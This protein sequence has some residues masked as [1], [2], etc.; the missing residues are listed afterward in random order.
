MSKNL[1]KTM[2]GRALEMVGAVLMALFCFLGFLLVLKLLFPSGTPLS[3]LL[4]GAG[5][6]QSPRARNYLPE[7][8]SVEPFAASLTRFNNSVK[9]KGSGDIAWSDARQNMQ[10]YNR[11]AVQTA[12]DSSA[13]ISFDPSNSLEMAS[14]SLVI[15]KS[16]TKDKARNERKSVLLVIDG[17]LRGTL[18]GSGK[19]AVQV[20]MALPA[21]FARV[22]ARKGADGS[23]DFTVR[24]NPD[25]SSTVTVYR[26]VAELT[27]RGKTV[28]VGANLSS[29][30]SL[31][32]QPSN[33]RGLLAAPEPTLPAAAASIGY[34]DLPPKIR[35][36]W[37]GPA[38]ASGYRLLLAGD[39]GFQ[40]PIID[41][42]LGQAGYSHG[43]LRQGEYFWKVTT[44][45][46]WVEGRS[47]A[48]RRFRV[49]QDR[50][51]PELRV[52]FPP[53]VLQGREFLLRGST[54]PGAELFINHL[55]E[56]TGARGEFA[57]QL[58][59]Q[60]G[61][62]LITVEAV[63]AAGNISYKTHKVLSQF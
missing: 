20:E 13:V 61:V 33:P 49:V 62:N 4:K 51:P 52:Q 3:V 45:D 46:G 17:A 27:A 60:H 22:N 48:V 40:K 41:E 12:K 34:R 28:R 9:A 39:P 42:K 30:V 50:E 15:V 63:D 37:Q 57:R 29:T 54:E 32:G 36:S 16:L 5:P 35:F 8:E 58:L 55:P 23:A 53:P 11:D 43:N 18:T 25:K 1:L 38:E 31:T 10:L 44:L 14:N 59:F 19:D 56:P 26:G 21:G 24:V 6:R 2:A 47:S 7:G